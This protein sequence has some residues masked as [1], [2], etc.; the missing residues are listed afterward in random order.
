MFALSAIKGVGLSSMNNLVKERTRSGKF[1]D[2]IDFML[3]LD[4]DVINKRQLEKLI[5]AGAFDSIHQNRAFL[6]NNVMNFIQIFGGSKFVS[7]QQSNLFEDVKINIEDKKIFNH[8]VDL[9]S[10]TL[11]LNYELEVIGF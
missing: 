3:R 11:Q 2:I 4:G 5:Q 9:W 1:T 6:F 10:S 8:K 7:T